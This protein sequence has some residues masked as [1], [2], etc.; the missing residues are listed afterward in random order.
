MNRVSTL[1]AVFGL[2]TGL[3]ALSAPAP[4]QEVGGGKVMEVL[5]FGTDPC[6][7]STESEVVVCRR[8]DER[9]RYRIPERLRSGGSR[10]ER[11]AWVNKTRALE[12]AG[13]T[14][15]MSCSPVGPAGHTGCLEQAIDQARR[16]VREATEADTAPED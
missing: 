11:Q 14:G 6:P 10:Q 5:V 15:I 16:E 7:R 4:A 8:L 13:R 12:V 9:E 3:A 2:A 1:S